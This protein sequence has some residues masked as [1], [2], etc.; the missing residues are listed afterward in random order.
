VQC[1][2]V[3]APVDIFTPTQRRLLEARFAKMHVLMF[4]TTPDMANKLPTNWHYIPYKLNLHYV[5][6]RPGR[7]VA[8]A[9]RRVDS[10]RWAPTEA[11][12][13]PVVHAPWRPDQLL[14][15]T[16]P[17]L[18]TYVSMGRGPNPNKKWTWRLKLQ[19]RALGCCRS[20][21]LLA[22]RGL[23]ALRM[24]VAS[25]AQL[26][27]L[28]CEPHMGLTCASRSAWFCAHDDKATYTRS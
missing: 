18:S 10:T 19:A 21:A 6:A 12:A 23:L 13:R 28:C 16:R 5:P 9:G 8:I 26:L 2:F 15:V 1:H 3:S 20:K 22:L 25:L 11:V 14:S 27:L 4:D 24:S 7:H 17:L